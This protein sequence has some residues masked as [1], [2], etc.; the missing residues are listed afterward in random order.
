[1]DIDY[2]ERPAQ[3]IKDRRVR[4]LSPP[5]PGRFRRVNLLEQNGFFAQMAPGALIR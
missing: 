5:C 1:M 4:A 3:S 2:Q